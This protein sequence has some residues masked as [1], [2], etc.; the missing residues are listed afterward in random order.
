MCSKCFLNFLIICSKSSQTLYKWKTDASS[1]TYTVI[2]TY[3]FWWETW[4]CFLFLDLR[5]FSESYSGLE[6]DYRGLIHV[7]E[8]LQD[9]ELCMK[10]KIKLQKWTSLRQKSNSDLM[11]P[12]IYKTINLVPIDKIIERFDAS[13]TSTAQIGA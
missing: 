8:K 6:Y 2:W 7:Y 1:T 11:G 4:W 5:L 10:F 9:D 3:R 12:D 13:S